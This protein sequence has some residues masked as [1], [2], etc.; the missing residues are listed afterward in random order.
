M[1]TILLDDLLHTGCLNK[2]KVYSSFL[3]KDEVNVY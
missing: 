1:G 3:G 2:K